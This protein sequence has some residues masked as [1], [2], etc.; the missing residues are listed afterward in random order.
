MKINAPLNVISEAALRAQVKAGQPIELVCH[1]DAYLKGPSWYGVWTVSVRE[2]A[3]HVRHLVTARANAATGDISI[4]EF[5]TISGVVSF[6]V[7]LEFGQAGVPSTNG[8]H[9]S[10]ALRE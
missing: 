6:L 3:G 10:M 9:L 2:N 1:E 5:K 7:G 4:R 8:K